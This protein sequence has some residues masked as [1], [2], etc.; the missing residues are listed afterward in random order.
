MWSKNG[1]PVLTEDF[2]LAVNI[3]SDSDAGFFGVARDFCL[4][5][6]GFITAIKTNCGGE[7]KRNLNCRNEVTRL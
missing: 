4:P 1:M 3:K 2:F 7:T 5:G 6:F